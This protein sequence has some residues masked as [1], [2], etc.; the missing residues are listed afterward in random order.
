MPIGNIDEDAGRLGAGVYAKGAG[1]LVT[2]V[3]ASALQLYDVSLLEVSQSWVPQHAVLSLA[4]VVDIVLQHILVSN[5][6][7]TE[8]GR[9]WGSNNFA[10]FI[11]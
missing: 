7:Y 9:S 11:V 10:C 2:D 8:L 5:A 6:I 1:G 3:V 4:V